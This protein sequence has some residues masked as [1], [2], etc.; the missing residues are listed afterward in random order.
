MQEI[1][2]VELSADE[3]ST[4]QPN[5]KDGKI[6]SVEF[7]KQEDHDQAKNI[8]RVGNENHHGANALRLLENFMLN[9]RKHYTHPVAAAGLTSSGSLQIKSLCIYINIC[10]H[11]LHL[12]S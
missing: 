6:P 1:E 5:Q 7:Q 8:G 3:T 2:K 12:R 9:L 4:P 11:I 10:L